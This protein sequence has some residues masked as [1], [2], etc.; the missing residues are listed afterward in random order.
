MKFPPQRK[1]YNKNE[2]K[3][4]ILVLSFIMDFGD[5]VDIFGAGIPRLSW[6]FFLA[7][8]VL[9]TWRVDFCDLVRSRPGSGESSSRALLC[10]SGARLG[11]PRFP[12]IL[13]LLADWGVVW[14]ASSA[15]CLETH[16]WLC[17][18]GVCCWT[19]G[20]WSDFTIIGS[21]VGWIVLILKECFGF[22][23]CWPW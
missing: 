7:L 17:V 23:R 11:L 4:K 5:F 10:V 2:M 6:L 13:I 16:P 9:A 8:V 14:S 19:F 15:R 20:G 22:L 3:G 21:F 12:T 1:C 18:F